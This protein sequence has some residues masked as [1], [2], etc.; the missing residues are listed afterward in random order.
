MVNVLRERSNGASDA[1]VALILPGAG[2]TTQAPLLYWPILALAEAGWEVWSIDWHADI[3]DAT[4]QDMQGFVE[5][6]LATAEVTLPAPPELVLAKSLGT[7]AL[8]YLAHRDVRAVWL[9]PI[10]TDPV[11]ADALARV[12]SGRHLAVGGSADPS[13]RPDLISN[14][15]ARLVTIEAADHRLEVTSTQWRQSAEVQLTVVDQVVAHLLA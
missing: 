15:S 10:L 1:R 5:S 8:P 11:V 7:F 6:A 12:T 4:H 9:T 3:D 14:A 13:W 2:Y